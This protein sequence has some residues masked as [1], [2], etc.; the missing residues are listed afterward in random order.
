MFRPHEKHLG[1][2]EKN[3]MG[4]FSL[5]SEPNHYPYIIII[6]II[7]IIIGPTNKILCDKNIEHRDR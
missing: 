6:I 2:A 5:P 3:T 7:I 4:A 1:M